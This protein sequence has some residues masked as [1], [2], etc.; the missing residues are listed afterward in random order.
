MIIRESE[1]NFGPFDENNVCKIEQSVLY[2]NIKLI[3]QIAE[4]ILKK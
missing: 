2:E 1:M 4:F 3:V